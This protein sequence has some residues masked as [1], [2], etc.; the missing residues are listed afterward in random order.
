MSEINKN[1]TKQP[2]ASAEV[3]DTLN[4]RYNLGIQEEDFTMDS[5]VDTVGEHYVTAKFT[6]Q[7]FDKEFRFLVKVV[8]KQKKIVE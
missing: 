7:E 8:I 5:Q 3:L 2:L 1:V 4:K 6:S